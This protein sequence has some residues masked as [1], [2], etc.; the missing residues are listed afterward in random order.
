MFTTRRRFLK[1]GSLATLFAALPLKNVLG[2]RWKDHDG[3]PAAGDITMAGLPYYSRQVFDRYVNSVFQL[4]SG[5]SMVG[6]TL[7]KVSDMAAPQG[8]ECFTLLFRG[9]ATINRQD[10]YTLVH[11]ALGA[12][13]L[14][15]VK[16]A[17]NKRG[18][19][20]YLATINRPLP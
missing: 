17:P 1:A 13:Q 3:N 5:S 2:Q 7:E 11:P 14:L 8:G 12:F 19:Q 16:V 20:G 6:V 9:G 4:H 10:T 18:E 15:M